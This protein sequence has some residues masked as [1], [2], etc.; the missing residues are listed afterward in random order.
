MKLIYL[1]HLEKVK[2]DDIWNIDETACRL[3]PQ[4]SRGWALGG[5]STNTSFAGSSAFVTVTLAIPMTFAP[6]TSQIIYDGKTTKSI[7]PGPRHE[8]SFEL[9]I[10][11]VSESHFSTTD[12]LLQLV[13]C[14][15]NQV[16]GEGKFICIL[17]CAPTHTRASFCEKV[18]EVYP[19]CVFCDIQ[20]RK[21]F[22]QTAYTHPLDFAVVRPSV[23]AGADP[24]GLVKSKP[25]LRLN[26]QDLVGS[27]GARREIREK[28]WQFLQLQS[29][30]GEWQAMVDEADVLNEAGQMRQKQ[31]HSNTQQ[32][33]KAD[34]QSARSVL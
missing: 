6:L 11:A 24:M 34:L 10:A 12:S 16:K 20:L 8:L 14:L 4:A 15:Q 27:T 9:N 5:R 22:L 26:L 25:I 7:S 19:R 18:K 17:D 2:P 29:T 33:S 28:A 13:G 3:L 23:L 32:P 1:M 31:H 21:R 30:M